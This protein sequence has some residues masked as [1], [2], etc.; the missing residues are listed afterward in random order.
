MA[1]VYCMAAGAYFSAY[2]ATT[3]GWPVGVSMLCSP[4]VGGI[5]A[6]FPALLLRKA[7]GFTTAIVSLALVIILQTVISNLKFLGGQAGFF[8]I[9]RMPILLP[10]TIFILIVCGVLV[11]R[12]DNSRIGRAAEMLFYNRDMAAAFGVSMSGISV[13]LQV[14]SGSLS[15]LAGAIFTF[16][17]RALFPDAFGFS[18][19]INVAVMVFVG[20]TLTMWGV[21]IFGPILW[22]I[23]LILPN[24]VAEYHEIIYGCL[25]IIIL[26]WRPEGVVGKNT[27]RAIKT[28]LK[29]ERI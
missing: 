8:G 23:P 17:V 20:G 18:V 26:I 9:P 14:L 16:K 10:I 13:F 4:L 19:L 21:V 24:V 3:W 6:F 2:S 29:F 1:P 22:G 25:L 27:V 11:Y 12:I 7:P 28:K 5:F 15:G